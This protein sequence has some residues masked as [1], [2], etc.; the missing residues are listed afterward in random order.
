MLATLTGTMGSLGAL[1]K[2]SG[3]I[4]HYLKFRAMTRLENKDGL[5]FSSSDSERHHVNM[6]ILTFDNAFKRIT[7]HLGHNWKGS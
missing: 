6:K 3:G 5:L 4:G 7:L 2:R 1:P